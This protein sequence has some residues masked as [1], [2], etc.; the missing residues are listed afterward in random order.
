MDQEIDWANIAHFAP[1]D[2]SRVCDFIEHVALPS[3]YLHD[4]NPSGDNWIADSG[5]SCNMTRNQS[6]IG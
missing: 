2:E 5:V 4:D 1:P 3:A 6:S